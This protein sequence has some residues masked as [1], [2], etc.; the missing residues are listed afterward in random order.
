MI[1][2]PS[3]RR[4]ILQATLPQIALL[5]FLALLIIG[6]A[7]FIAARSHLST[8]HENYADSVTVNLERNLDM[9]ARQLHN[10]A[11]NDLVINGLIDT[12][13]RD[14][15]LPL[16]IQ[17]LQITQAPDVPLALFNY[18]GHPLLEKNWQVVPGEFDNVWQ[19]DV[20]QELSLYTEIS[21]NGILIAA[22]IELAG[23]AE[24]ALVMYLKS[25]EW[26]LNAP[27]N[28]ATQLVVS[29]GGTILLSSRPALYPQGSYFDSTAQSGQFLYQ[30][31]WR[32][33]Q[34]ISLEPVTS[35]YSNVFWLIPVLI[36][37]IALVLISA[38]YSARL[39]ANMSSA[40][41][42]RL[43]RNLQ[44]AARSSELPPRHPEK[45]RELE[46]IHQAF[47]KLIQD[48]SLLSLSNNQFSDVIHS[49]QE[50]LLVV[51]N[52]YQLLLTNQRGELF[53]QKFQLSPAQL[54]QSLVQDITE[55]N[56]G[57]TAKYSRANEKVLHISWQLAPLQNKQG[58][59]IGHVLVGEDITERLQLEYDIQVRNRAIEY[60]SV[61]MTIVKTSSPSYP[62]EY[63]NQAF[64]QMT[65]YRKAEL[66]GNNTYQMLCAQTTQQYADKILAKVLAGKKCEMTLQMRHK[67]G[68]LYYNRLSLTPLVDQDNVITHYLG[69]QQDV[70]AQ[71]E[72]ARHLEDARLRAEESTQLKSQFLASMS[73]EI[74]TPINGIYGML[75]ALKETRLNDKQARYV[76][77]ATE[78]TSNLLH[79]I[80][81]I[82]DFSKIEAGKLTIEQHDFNLAVMLRK[83]VAHYQVE[84]RAKNVEIVLQEENCHQLVCGDPVRIR[85]IIS[86]LLSNAVKFTEQGQITVSATLATTADGYQLSLAVSDTGI[87]IASHKLQSVFSMFSQADISTTRKFGGTGLGLSISQQLVELMG[88]TIGVESTPGEGSTFRVSITLHGPKNPQLPDTDSTTSLTL[89]EDHLHSELKIL[90]VEDN[91][92]NRI[93]ATEL[94][95]G[96]DITIAEDGEQAI[97]QLTHGQ[98]RFD[99]IL[100]DCHMPV[101]DG[102]E[103]TRRI[104]AGQAGENYQHIPIIAMTANAMSGDKEQCLEQGM[105]DYI[106]KPFST[107]EI[108]DMMSKW[109]Q[110]ISSMTS[111]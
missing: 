32:D 51:D 99:L 89:R 27:L 44:H 71:H 62:L 54:F 4:K 41:L 79:I 77:L 45:A 70:T 101:M 38:L 8:L 110:K 17:S 53:L 76:S 60:A 64:E 73:H 42:R 36:V 30:K 107:Q 11:S 52:D 56:A 63:V 86:N 47:T 31:P 37:S 39:A 82:L 61:G 84:S 25:L 111:I 13:Y 69:I 81:D 10:I 66:I 40:S 9:T 83:I 68:R 5:S 103:A 72:A 49:M 55:N 18:A 97:S 74:R 88:G 46:Q 57:Y 19:N 35:A 15:Y 2:L 23:A 1:H 85:Q 75:E 102:F 65:G 78:S 106:S 50:L 95:Q 93:V 33:Y 105:S 104:R 14:Y 6:S 43:H 21:E 94:L 59:F 87:G 3:L 109:Q 67:D 28:P 16:F 98:S 22:P 108:T 26:L 24:G 92:I 96:Y 58:E 20:L 7:I 90:L 12:Q 29:E 100:M 34:V 80:N 91:E 48:V